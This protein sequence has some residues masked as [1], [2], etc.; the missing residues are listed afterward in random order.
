MKIN[1]PYVALISGISET[2]ARQHTPKVA[3]GHPSGTLRVEA[4]SIEEGSG[5]AVNKV[6]MN[7]SAWVL[8]EGLVRVSDRF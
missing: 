2:A 3:F 6:V 1:R 5:W 4:E 7:R 8:V